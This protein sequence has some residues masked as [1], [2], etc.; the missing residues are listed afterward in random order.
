METRRA[1]PVLSF[2]SAE[3]QSV[4]FFSIA[5]WYGAVRG[6]H[7]CALDLFTVHTP[8]PIDAREPITSLY[9]LGGIFATA[10][11]ARFSEGARP[12]HR[13]LQ[14]AKEAAGNFVTLTRPFSPPSFIFLSLGGRE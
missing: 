6:G 9:R 1:L 12:S 14:R 3:F 8:P 10:S 13:S 2:L 4:I 11:L 7:I 5:G